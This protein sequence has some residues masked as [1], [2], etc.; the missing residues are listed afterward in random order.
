MQR[1]PLFPLLPAL[2][3]SRVVMEAAIHASAIMNVRQQR[4]QQKYLLLEPYA[5]GLFA[6]VR[7]LI[8]IA[9]MSEFA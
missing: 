7:Q 6:V 5:V 1:L 8:Y 3:P 9:F 2:T 4:Q